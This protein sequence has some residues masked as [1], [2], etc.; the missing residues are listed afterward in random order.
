MGKEK[1]IDQV[2]QAPNL[3]MTFVFF[4]A[5]AATA[6]Y[7]LNMERTFLNLIKIDIIDVATASFITCTIVAVFF[8][9]RSVLVEN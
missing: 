3:V 5:V 4:L 1:I 7:G 8:C 2:R 6:V 9:G